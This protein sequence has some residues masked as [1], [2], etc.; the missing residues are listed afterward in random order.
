MQGLLPEGDGPDDAVPPPE[1]EAGQGEVGAAE[2]LHPTGHTL[3]PT[4]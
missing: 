1:E 3:H 2:P 4:T